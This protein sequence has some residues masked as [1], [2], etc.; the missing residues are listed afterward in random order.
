MPVE[1]KNRNLVSGEQQRAQE[2]ARA[3][4]AARRRFGVRTY[5]QVV[6]E[7]IPRYG[8]GPNGTRDGGSGAGGGN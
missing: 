5:A 2:R 8:G 6:R 1:L 4:V 3:W 7:G